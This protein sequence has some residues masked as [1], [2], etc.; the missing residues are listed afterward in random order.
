[1]VVF[2][3]L[4]L[5][6]L[7]ALLCSC[8]N[9][10]RT[11][12]ISQLSI[13]EIRSVRGVDFNMGKNGGPVVLRIRSISGE[14]YGLM[15]DIRKG[16]SL[17]EMAIGRLQGE[18]VTDVAFIKRNSQAEREIREQLMAYIGNNFVRDDAGTIIAVSNFAIDNNATLKMAQL[19]DKCLLCDQ[20]Q[21]D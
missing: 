1:M 15:I 21:P 19:I 13:G 4:V 5:I 20:I 16:P 11:D 3:S 9:S 8:S 17:G 18:E 6:G 2:R 14:E 10:D 12:A 7:I